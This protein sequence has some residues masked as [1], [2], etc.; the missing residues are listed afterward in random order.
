MK[1]K[2]FVLKKWEMI[3]VINKMMK[4]LEKNKVFKKKKKWACQNFQNTDISLKWIKKIL[5]LIPQHKMQL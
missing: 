3:H 4:E 2:I 1:S 5:M